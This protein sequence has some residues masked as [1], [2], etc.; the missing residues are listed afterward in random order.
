MELKLDTIKYN[1]MNKQP[2]YVIDARKSD[3]H[4]RAVENIVKYMNGQK[5]SKY[6]KPSFASAGLSY[7]VSHKH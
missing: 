4:C 3:K 2:M 1:D 6:L 7:Q 5:G